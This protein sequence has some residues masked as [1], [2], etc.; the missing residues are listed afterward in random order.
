MIPSSERRKINAEWVKALRKDLGINQE[1]LAERLGVSRSAVAR[2]ET[3]VQR[4][5]KLAVKVLLEF[6][7]NNR[8]G[9]ESR[10]D[11]QIHA[12]TV[13]KRRLISRSRRSSHDP[14][15][16]I[17]HPGTPQSKPR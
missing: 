5:T 16:R 10:D 2:W 6:A 12:S 11:G 1:T 14:V 17:P 9:Q 3:N 15:Q 4:P 7:V 13:H 8:D